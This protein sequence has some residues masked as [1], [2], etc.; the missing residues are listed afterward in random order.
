MS[1]HRI[2]LGATLACLGAAP[3]AWADDKP[4]LGVPVDEAAVS[5]LDFVILPDGEGLPDG[6]GDSATGERL[7][8]K[9]CLACHGANGQDGI[10]DVLVGGHGTLASVEPNKTIGS[11]WPYATT[12][13]DYIRRAMPY[14]TPGS[15]TDD[16]VY[17]LTAYLLFLNGIVAET[18]IMSAETLPKVRMP[19]RD[20]FVWAYTPK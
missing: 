1:M 2:V 18:D 11:Y 7:Y 14:P 15:L 17:S 19:N 6:S 9:N 13:F 10:N 20:N 12:L 16:E 4:R 3:I 5:A 8:T